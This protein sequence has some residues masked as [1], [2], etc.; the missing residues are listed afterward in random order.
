MNHRVH[1]DLYTLLKI[2][3]PWLLRLHVSQCHTQVTAEPYEVQVIP[4]ALLQE[5]LSIKNQEFYGLARTYTHAHK[6][7]ESQTAWQ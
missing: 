5:P 7:K 6:D 4:I 2:C 1:L 3:M